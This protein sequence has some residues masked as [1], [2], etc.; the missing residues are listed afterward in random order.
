MV[1]PRVIETYE[2]IQ[3]PPTVRDFDQMARYQRNKRQIVYAALTKNGLST[4][5]GLEIGPG[6]GYV[7]LEWLKATQD[8]SLTGLEISMEMIKVATRNA[9]EYGFENRVNY[10]HGNATEQ[11]PFE[12]DTFDAV[13]S[14]SSLHEWE[15]PGNVFNEIHRVLKPGG[16]FLISDLRRDIS[17]FIRLMM[18]STVK[19]SSMKAGLLTSLAAAYTADEISEILFN[20]KLNSFRVVK[21]PFGM[22]VTGMKT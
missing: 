19:Q 17:F 15:N 18:K 2:G 22:Y 14:Y 12:N 20:T 21:S 5:I 11:F 9:A 4:G 8:T 10:I 6:P 16:R 13:F 7:G 3:Q 1:K